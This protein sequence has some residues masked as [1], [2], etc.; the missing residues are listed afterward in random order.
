[1]LQ[2]VSGKILERNINLSAPWHESFAVILI[3]NIHQGNKLDI[4]LRKRNGL[5]VLWGGLAMITVIFVHLCICYPVTKEISHAWG[6]HL[7]WHLGI[8]CRLLCVLWLLTNP[9]K[10]RFVFWTMPW[11]VWFALNFIST[12]QT[13]E[14]TAQYVFQPSSEYFREED[15]TF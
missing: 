7:R 8:L 1:M 15:K 3:I 5:T 11:C 6:I 10:V 9:T 13:T 12:R 4:Y 2:T 14:L